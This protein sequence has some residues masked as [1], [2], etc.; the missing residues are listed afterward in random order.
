MKYI[1]VLCYMENKVGYYHKRLDT[2]EIFYVGI[3][4]PYRPYEYT[5]RNPHWHHI[6]D[7]VGYEVI[8]IKENISWEEACEWEKIRIK[9][10]GRRDLSLGPLVNMT[11]GGDGVTGLDCNGEKNGFYGKNHTEYTKEKIR[12]WNKENHP[13]NPMT[14]NAILLLSEKIKQQYQNGRQAPWTDKKRPIHDR[15]K[16]SL[17]KSGLSIE[18]VKNIQQLYFVENIR[19]SVIHKKYQISRDFLNVLLNDDVWKN[20]Y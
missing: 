13:Y 15:R 19:K 4:E 1:H 6:V 7:K 17:T 16:I 5:S 12:L 20:L 2:N 10:I 9:E 8:V 11:D 14:E 3:G 18:D